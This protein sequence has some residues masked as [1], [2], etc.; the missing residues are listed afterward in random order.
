VLN[1]SLLLCKYK[2]VDFLFEY[3]RIFKESKGFLFSVEFNFKLIF[4]LSPFDDKT[5]K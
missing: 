4:N 5:K 2:E 1:F 3:S